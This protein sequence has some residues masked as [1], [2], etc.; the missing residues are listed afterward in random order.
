MTLRGALAQGWQG[1]V[2]SQKSLNKIKRDKAGRLSGDH[3]AMRG[4]QKT[5]GKK[6]AKTA[7]R[8][9]WAGDVE[10]EWAEPISE[11]AKRWFSQHLEKKLRLYHGGR[12]TQQ[13]AVALTIKDRQM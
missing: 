3:I 7:N 5:K 2:R 4:S 11:E 9:V 12:L 6:K 1:M 13:A 10:T 8:E